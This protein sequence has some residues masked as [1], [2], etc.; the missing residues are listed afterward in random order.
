M[1][2]IVISRT[3]VRICGRKVTIEEC[4][5]KARLP[6]IH[7]NIRSSTISSHGNLNGEKAGLLAILSG[8]L[9]F[10]NVLPFPRLF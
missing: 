3:H 8:K 7:V 6:I 9:E 10:S 1:S 2:A 4:P 5:G